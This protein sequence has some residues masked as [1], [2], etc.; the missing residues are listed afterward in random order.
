MVPYAYVEK[1][2]GPEERPSVGGA[3]RRATLIRK[4]RAE[5]RNPVVLVDGGD[6]F[7]RGPLTNAYEG[8]PDVEAMNALGYEVAVLGNNEF[9]A[10]DAAERED[11]MGSQAV[12]LNMVKRARF[13]WI[14]ANVKDGHGS[15]LEGVQPFVVRQWKG[16]RVGFLGLTAPI[17]GT[18]PQTRGWQFAEAIEVAKSWIPR[19]RA[20]CDVL[21][22]VTHLGTEGDKQLAAQTSGLDAIVGGHSHTFLYHALEVKNAKDV[23]VPIVQDGEYGVNLGRLDL[24]LHRGAGGAWSLAGY[25]SQLLPIGPELAE[26]PD[27][28]EV[29]EPYFQPFRKVVGRLERVA[30]TPAERTRQASQ[31]VADALQR[32]SGADLA[33]HPVG[34]DLFD[35]FRR[36]EVT[37]LDVF[38]ALPFKDRVSLV[39]LTGA[40]IEKLRSTEPKTLLSAGAPALKPDARY[41]VAMINFVG[42]TIYRLPDTQL[43]DSDLDVRDAVIQELSRTAR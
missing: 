30:D 24:R 34:A 13:A 20:Q 2:K 29:L 9:K 14:G 39:E 7:T 16:V 23:P 43:R 6:T 5:I 10:K 17:S 4:L 18:Y 32:S 26:A 31:L 8:I 41:R 33:L 12:L 28:A 38:A 21:I 27:V 40:E 11:A 3:A 22:A 15:Q 42:R 35:A 25:Q 36:P 1:G 19:A 37:R